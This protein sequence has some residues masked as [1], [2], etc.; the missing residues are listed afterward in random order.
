MDRPRHPDFAAGQ[1][2]RLPAG[3]GRH[4][5]GRAGR[6]ST[7]SSCRPTARRGCSRRPG[8]PTGRCRRTT[9]RRTRRSRNLLY[10]QQRNPVRAGDVFRHPTTATSPAATS[11]ARRCS[12]TCVTTYRL[13]E[14]HTAGGMSRWLPY[15]SELQPEFFCEVSPELAA[16][17]G[18]EH[19]GWATIVT[20]RGAIEA[21]VLV[22]DRMAPLHRAGP[23]AAPDRAALP[24]GRQRLQHR[25]LRQ[26]AAVDVP[27]PERATSRRSRPSRATSGPGRRPRG[28]A[29]LELVEEYQRRAGIT[30]RDRDGGVR[31]SI[32]AGS[33]ARGDATRPRER[34]R[35]P[36]AAD[37]VLHRHLGVHR[38]QGLRGGLQGVERRPRGRPELHRHVLRQ[39]RGLGADTWRHVAF[40]EQRR[41]VG[42][43]ATRT[44]DRATTSAG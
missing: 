3:D 25:R 44:G 38:L 28:P 39:H 41:P 29:R 16:E 14:H 4:R 40:I 1:A 11:R 27:G 33:A 2:R 9:S 6:R 31:T 35:R 37:G 17:R 23:H 34:L 10:G 8:W 19:L 13:T 43:E 26:R 32:L 42:T 30:E 20:A 24:L 5:A 7:R 21:R 12:R 22:T 15:L 18:L 36:P